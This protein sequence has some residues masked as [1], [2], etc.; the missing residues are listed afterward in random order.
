MAQANL[1]PFTPTPGAFSNSATLEYYGT[2][3][4]SDIDATIATYAQA[5]LPDDAQQASYYELFGYIDPDRKSRTDEFSLTRTLMEGMDEAT[6][7]KLN[8]ITGAFYTIQSSAELGGLGGAVGIIKSVLDITGIGNDILAGMTGL[9]GA[10]GAGIANVLGGIFGT[11]SIAK[12][13]GDG[14][15]RSAKYVEATSKRINA[16]QTESARLSA[17]SDGNTMFRTHNTF[18]VG[19]GKTLISS[20]TVTAI[21]SPITNIGGDAY[22]TNVRSIEMIADHYKINTAHFH[23]MS[24][25][26]CTIAGA[27]GSLRFPLGLELVGGQVNIVGQ[28]M[29]IGGGSLHL[30]GGNLGGADIISSAIKDIIPIPILQSG[31]VLS[32]TG[33]IASAALNASI[34]ASSNTYAIDAPVIMLNCGLAVG[35]MGLAAPK[36]MGTIEQQ[37]GNPNRVKALDPIA[38]TQID[39]LN[40]MPVTQPPS[41]P[42]Q[43]RELS[44]DNDS[45]IKPFD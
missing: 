20:N 22:I 42:Y 34:H 26:S 14:A 21:D 33:T 15:T 10:I 29:N 19:S 32:S 37:T 2:T 38:P 25:D 9:S 7:K 6:F 8:A 5:G 39:N 18:F 44:I 30:Q 1:T 31:L 23:L 12:V 28:N 40:P 16:V 43:G 24:D 13:I 35:A 36:N 41:N 4:V 3:A 27:T 45:I 17:A 11:D